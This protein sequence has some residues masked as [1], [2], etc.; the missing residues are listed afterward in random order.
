MYGFL[1]NY[2]KDNYFL[3][4][5]DDKLRHHPHEQAIL[6]KLEK[7]KHKN[8]NKNKQEARSKITRQSKYLNSWE[9][10]EKII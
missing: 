2:I 5:E 1:I 8:N 7:Q 4:T 9:E 10:T 6:C 3:L